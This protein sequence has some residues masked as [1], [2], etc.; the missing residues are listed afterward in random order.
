MNQILHRFKKQHKK[1]QK[2]K[3]IRD[4]ERLIKRK[5]QSTKSLVI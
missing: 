3:L 5:P 1:T 2:I 4:T